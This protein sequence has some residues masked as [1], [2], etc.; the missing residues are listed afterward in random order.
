MRNSGFLWIIVAI[1]AVL[2][3]YVF[4]PVKMVSQSASPRTRF[5]IFIVYWALSVAILLILLLLPFLNYEN[6]P[7]PLR[8]YLFAMVVGLFFSELI[9]SVFFFIDDVRRAMMWVVGKLFSNPSVEISQDADG[10]TRSTFLSWLG[11]GLGGT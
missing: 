9:A 7:K 11:L 3:I 10:I 5:I 8:T 4:Q 2:N 1:M 6:W